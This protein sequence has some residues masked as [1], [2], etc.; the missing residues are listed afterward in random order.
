MDL[1]AQDFLAH[2]VHDVADR[3]SGQEDRMVS[4]ILDGEN[5][6]G[7]YGPRAPAFL[8]ALYRR[9]TE[10]ADVQ[11]VTFSGYLGGEPD[12][13]VAAHPTEQQ[14]RV[15]E[16]F[17][18]S[19]ID[20]AGS[21]PGV[22]LGTWAGEPDENDAW[23]LLGDARQ[24]L[25]QA[26]A[27]PESNELAF[28]ALYMAE[29]SDWYWWL[30]TDHPAP[31]DWDFEALFRQHLS[32]AYRL[33]GLEPPPDLERALV[34]WSLTWS[35][36]KPLEAIRPMEQMAIRTN[37]PGTVR[38]KLEPVGQ[39]GESVMQPVSGP[40]ALAHRYEVLL[41]PFGPDVREVRLR[42]QC[43]EH[44]AEEAGVCVRPRERVV[45]VAEPEA[46]AAEAEK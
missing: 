22:D 30:G 6:Y 34:P 18:G 29:G 43:L 38:W 33:A 24:A 5:T 27:T 3:L 28:D 31:K 25:A 20:E 37:C 41:G 1:A 8:R 23:K 46:A 13:Q 14:Q 19:W 10:S 9:L 12:R 17:T 36:T 15:Y 16:L 42:F 39:E 2:V 44:L 21:A 26:G 45:R 35:F 40:A 7:A 32:N 4:V 11:T